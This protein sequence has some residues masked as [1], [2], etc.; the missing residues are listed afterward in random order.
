MDKSKPTAIVLGGTYPHIKLLKNLSIRG[1]ETVLIDYYSVPCAAPHADKHIQA[2]TLDREK[3]LEIAIAENAA[4]VISSCIDQANLIACSVA[5][6][7]NLPHPYNTEK[8]NIVTN[9]LLMKEF[10]RSNNIPSSDFIAIRNP[11]QTDCLTLNYPLIV[12]PSDSNSSK[13]V[14][15]IEK[16]DQISEAIKSAIR[17]SR[18]REAIVEEFIEGREVGMD[19]Y[20]NNGIPKL[21][22]TK[23]RRKIPSTATAAQ[24]IYGCFWPAE[25]SEEEIKES[26]E[27]AGRIATSLEIRDSPLMI[28]AIAGKDGISVIEFAARFGG[29][30]SFKVIEL[31]TGVD[32]IDL[33]I[34]SFLHETVDILP[35]P[36]DFIFAETFLYSHE[37]DFHHIDID[38]SATKDGTIDHVHQYKTKGMHVGL[39]LTSNN[40]VGSIIVSARD[41]EEVKRKINKALNCVEVIDNEGNPQLRKDLYPHEPT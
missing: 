31:A 6:T 8:G 27:I 14:K 1:F 35:S 26:I 37:C 2:S 17:L 21:L 39:E 25:L 4:L 15:R 12:K 22:I 16:Q 34:R 5:E 19:F 28:Q 29:G 40:R 36:S 30:E 24:Q 23:E 10:M 9:K 38:E 20:I 32:I 3:V 13:G 18:S 7:L 11:S 33:S 41:R